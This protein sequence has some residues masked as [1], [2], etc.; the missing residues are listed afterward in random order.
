MNNL[1]NSLNDNRHL[2]RHWILSHRN[3]YCYSSF[4]TIINVNITLS[5]ERR[6]R[7]KS[8]KIFIYYSRDFHSFPHSFD[9]LNGKCAR[10]RK[11]YLRKVWIMH[12]FHKSV[13][14]TFLMS[15]LKIWK[16]M[17]GT[18][19]PPSPNTSS[20]FSCSLMQDKEWISSNF[21]LLLVIIIIIIRR[22]VLHPKIASRC[23]LY[24]N[25]RFLN[26]H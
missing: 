4:L 23:T 25:K 2:L 5:S 26:Y 7:W 16:M 13:N 19:F 8:R 14:K 6:R 1:S 24:W 9:N 22:A 15:F 3:F 11:K 12:I 21:L 18:I 10:K 20:T 17:Q